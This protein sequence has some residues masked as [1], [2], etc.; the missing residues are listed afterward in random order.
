MADE[1]FEKSWISK[2]THWLDKVAG[3]KIQKKCYTQI[4]Q[5][6]T[7]YRS[8]RHLLE[9]PYSFKFSITKQTFHHF[10][11]SFFNESLTHVLTDLLSVFSFQSHHL[12]DEILGKP[13]D[14]ED[15]TPV[16]SNV[17]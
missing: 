12:K 8:K 15:M 6:I 11:S 3:E 4:Y 2:F 17:F 9:F 16:C 7:Y 14:I 5:K 10:L 1:D 13:I